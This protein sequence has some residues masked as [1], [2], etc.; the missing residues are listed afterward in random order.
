MLLVFLCVS[1]LCA[2]VPLDGVLVKLGAD[3]ITSSD[4][5]QAR[6]LKL[7]DAGGGDQAILDALV[8][9]RLVLEELGRNPP[10]EP[11]PPAIA[12]RRAQW[13]ATLGTDVD[14]PALL[15][16]AGFSESAVQAWWRDDLRIAAYL[17]QRFPPSTNR[18]QAI[19]SWVAEL[20]QRAGIK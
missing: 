16:R 4:V 3:V 8:K 11:L 1:S 6:L 18:Q 9:R 15:A 13:V 12:A 5:R 14:L 19:A 10:A 17:D 20:R 7:V 2:Q